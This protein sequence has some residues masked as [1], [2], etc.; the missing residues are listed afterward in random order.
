MNVESFQS[1]IL[2]FIEQANLA[3]KWNR[4]AAYWDTT[5]TAISPGGNSALA[6]TKI[7]TFLCPSNG[8]GND[9]IGGS[10]A[11]AAIVL[12]GA[13]AGSVAAE[14]FQY[15]GAND[16]MPV[17]YTDINPVNGARNKADPASGIKG[18]F[19]PG[20]LTYNQSTGMSSAVDGTSNT[21]IVFEDAGRDQ[22]HVGAYDA[23]TT[24][25]FTTVGG[26]SRQVTV[27]ASA[28]LPS[29]KTVPNRWA[30]GDNASGVS[31]APQEETLIP[32]T[33]PII[34]NTKTPVGGSAATCLWTSNNCGPNDEPFSFHAGGGCYASFA[35]GSVHWIS[36]S[37]SA[38]V[39]RQLSDPADG[40]SPLKYE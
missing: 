40:E 9:Q 33:Q 24:K 2:A 5:A 19:K 15:Y 14:Q 18:S 16:Y 17:A 8:L 11:G 29:N 35:D 21:V 20:L 3:S 31:G 27:T 34:N 26:R 6:A 30:D 37:V 25:F 1:Q 12:A 36:E 7:A 39:M 32:R 4:T 38:Q 10:S 22:Q 13:T 28:D 23:T